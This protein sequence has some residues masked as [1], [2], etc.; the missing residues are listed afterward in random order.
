MLTCNHW[1]KGLAT[2][3]SELLLQFGFDGPG[4][5]KI[6]ADCYARNKGSEWVMQKIGMTK[7][8]HQKDFYPYRG[9]FDDRIHYGISATV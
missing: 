4:A 7:E 9:G 6:T 5:H 2:S 3:V 1:G 8:G